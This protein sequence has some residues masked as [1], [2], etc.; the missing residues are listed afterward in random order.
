[1]RILMVT[2]PI[3]SLREPF[4]GGTESF[5][6]S[7]AN[8]MVTAGHKVD[9][10]C[11]DADE[12]NKFNTIQLQESAFRMTDAITSETDGQKLYQAAQFGLFNVSDYDIIHFHS[13]YHAMFEFAFFHQ[14]QNIITLHSPVSQRLALTHRLNSTRSD[15][16]YVAVSQRLA[17][18]WEPHIS[19]PINVVQ[20]GIALSRLPDSAA[21]KDTGLVWVGR[22]CK[23][24]NPIGAIRAAKSLET[25]LTLYGPISDPDYFSEEIAPLLG[26]KIHYGGHVAQQTLYERISKAAALLITSKWKEPFG[27][28]TLE[29]LSMGTPVI[30]TSQAIPSELRKP[31]LTQAID[32]ENKRSLLAAYS[33]ALNIAPLDCKTFANAFDIS[34]T[35]KAY[36]CIYETATA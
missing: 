10:L 11:K 22:L 27:L 24:K 30:G 13:Y 29:S 2:S 34:Q 5:V 19:S 14:K 17:K 28:V 9:V 1:M 3:V 12:D 20:N 35:V 31:P 23:E 18:E 36:E 8:G 7:L 25:P 32:I 4:K 26:E 15:D 6:V 16:I 21:R 33:S